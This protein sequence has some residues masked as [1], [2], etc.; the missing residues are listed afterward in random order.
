MAHGDAVC[1]SSL[2]TRMIVMQTL[3]LSPLYRSFVGIDRLVDMVDAAARNESAGSG[4]PPF[5]IEESGEDSYRIEIAVAGF[6]ED[7]IEIEL[8]EQV[9]IISGR[10]DTEEKRNFLHRGIAERAFERR[11]NLAEHVVVDGASLENGLLVVE[12]RRELPEAKKPRK[13]AISRTRAGTKLLSGSKNKQ[14]A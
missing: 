9:L 4:Y 10:R 14:A 3:D 5:N 6:S 1:A 13:I 8:R 11:F 12:L 2:G 7:E